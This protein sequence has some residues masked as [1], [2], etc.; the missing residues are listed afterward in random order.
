MNGA[1]PHSR[2]CHVLLNVD[3]VLNYEHWLSY[4]IYWLDCPP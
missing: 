3:D 2:W 1:K 4:C